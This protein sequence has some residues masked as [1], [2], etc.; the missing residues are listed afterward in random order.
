MQQYLTAGSQSAE[1]L[2]QQYSPLV[3][4]IEIHSKPLEEPI[5]IFIKI[6]DV[7]KNIRKIICSIFDEYKHEA[8]K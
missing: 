5:H 7:A 2:I 1:Q 8:Y 3:I 6:T 4:G